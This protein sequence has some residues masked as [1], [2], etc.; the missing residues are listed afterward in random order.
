MS[1]TRRQEP[2]E[3]KPK[4]WQVKRRKQWEASRQAQPLEYPQPEVPAWK[5][6]G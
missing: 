2:Q 4:P 5:P 3:P 1:K 6:L